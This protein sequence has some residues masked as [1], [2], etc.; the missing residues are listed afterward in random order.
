[1]TPAALALQL[2]LAHAAAPPPASPC[3]ITGATGSA[4]DVSRAT[5]A[6]E[7]ART[8]FGQLLGSPAPDV[9]IVL[10]DELGYRTGVRG[11]TAVVY[12][13]TGR[14][15]GSV[16]GGGQFSAYGNDPWSDGLPHEIAHMLLA[17]HLSDSGVPV[18]AGQGGYGTPLPDWLDEAVAIWVE[19]AKSRAERLGEARAL[20]GAWLDLGAIMYGAHPGAANPAVMAMRD[21]APPPADL[22]L[23]AFYP[24][25]IALLGFVFDL[26]GSAAVQTLVGSLLADAGAGPRALL[27]LPGMPEDA[28]TLRDAWRSWLAG[29]AR[30]AAAR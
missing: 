10:W 20:P 16:P 28:E 23:A 7:T 12:W 5:R 8:R 6:C 21:G 26:G 2:L 27:S 4:A 18:S 17:A 9:E 30:S 14:A 13:P 11:S 19:P 29:S 24:R 22:A 25:S 15:L 1:V 3:E